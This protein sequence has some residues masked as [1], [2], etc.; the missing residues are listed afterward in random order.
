MD[1]GTEPGLEGA[2]QEAMRDRYRRERERRL[3]PDGADQYVE[4][5]GRFA[6]FADADPYADPAFDREP[7]HDD[8]DIAIIGGGFSGLLAA[9]RL[10]E[11]GV[12][13][14]RI[15]EAGADFG[16]TWYWNRYPGAQ[17]DTDAYCYL[18]LL[19][20]LGYMPTEKYAYAT[21]ILDHSRRIGHHYDLYPKAILQT[22][23]RSID[24]DDERARWH[25]RTDRDDALTARFVVMALGSITR[26]KL[27]GIPGIDEFGGHAFHTSRWDYAYTGGD[28]N[29]GMTGLADKRVAIIGTGASAVQCTPRVAADAAHVYV[30][31]RTPSSVDWRRNRPTDPGWWSSLQPGWQRERREN[32]NDQAAGRPV[33]VDLVD[34]GWTDI[35]RSI[36]SPKGAN[37]PRTKEERDL[38][39]EASD[40]RKMNEIRARV[41]ET[42]DDP[43]VAEALKPYYRVMCKRPTFNDEYLA[44]FNRDNVTLVD[45]SESRGV[46]R[47]TERGVVANGHEY[48]VDCIIYA[49][50][51][52]ISAD[53]RR[54][55][56]MEINGRGGVSLFDHWADGLR[57]L[58][59]LTT[60]GFPNWFY[61][62]VS[63]NAFSV[64]MTS[65]FDDQAK[66]IAYLIDETIRR[67]AATIEP[68]EEGQADWVALI[69]GFKVGG[70]GFLAACT[71]G[72]YNNEGS[73]QAGNAFFGAYTPGA[74]AFNRLLEDWR[75]AGE[76]E[77]MELVPHV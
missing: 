44:C 56:G 18:P 76:L 17:C 38:V 4:A 7:L 58:H 35:F 3:R 52:E 11:R 57:T 77:G 13:S 14:F 54:R 31:Q 26:P 2:E 70:A 43:A 48:E 55:L 67:K 61:V 60:R 29:G 75:A 50:G 69:N 68:S 33:D 49:T 53:F 23:V 72:Y 47:I 34:D 37:R 27:P 19:E 73:P 46:E 22:R 32:F 40:L 51:F 71:P 62:G 24:W 41:D 45:V 12:T 6:H 42:V 9:A 25:I 16:G 1:G 63:Q 20:E 5:A 30:F 66:H 74:S 28:T 15:I 39:V 8:I 65:M 36:S 21:E 64:N 59:G 10:S